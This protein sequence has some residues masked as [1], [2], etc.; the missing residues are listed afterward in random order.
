M[1]GT[2]LVIE[3][4]PDNRKLVTWI[5]EDEDYEVVCAETAEEGLELL[6]DNHFDAVLMDISLPGIDGK[7]ATRRIRAQPRWQELP[8]LALTAHAIKGEH[9]SI[10]A[11]GVTDL[12]TKPLDEGLLLEQLSTLVPSR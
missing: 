2:I 1:P 6:L 8:I 4:N 11:S 7:E 5:L 12:L 3:D 10:L 9:E